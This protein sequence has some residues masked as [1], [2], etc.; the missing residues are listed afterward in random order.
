MG[1]EIHFCNYRYFKIYIDIY[2]YIYTYIYI[3]IYIY[4]YLCFPWSRPMS[5]PRDYKIIT[6][7]LQNE[8]GTSIQNN[9]KWKRSTIPNQYPN[10]QHP[11]TMHV[12]D[13][14]P[15]APKIPSWGFNCLRTP[16][17]LHARVSPIH[18]GLTHLIGIAAGSYPPPHISLTI[19]QIPL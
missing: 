3:P 2:I 5:V 7:M 17:T 11:Y 16:K 4:L 6:N 14:T 8:K 1:H 13:N 12:K 18:K 19:S 10:R 9:Y 15:F